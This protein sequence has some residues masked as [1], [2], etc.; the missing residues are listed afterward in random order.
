LEVYPMSMSDKTLTAF[1]AETASNAPT[2]G[3]GSV[4][5]LTGALGCALAEMVASL[6]V[7]KAKFADSAP[8][9]EEILQ[10]GAALR[11]KLLAL[12]DEDCASFGQYMSALALPKDTPA[13]KDARRES[14]RAAA[15]A[16]AAAPMEMARAAAAALPLCERAVRLG[17]P[18]V[19][20]DALMATMLARTAVRSA[21]LNVRINLPSIGD[22]AAAAALDAECA[23][24]ESL[25]QKTEEELMALSPV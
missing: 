14:L 18:G 15:R 13:Q 3:G 21:V 6:T 10:E 7:G 20:T 5:A 22:E 19:V 25:A 12:I 11:A 23:R 17:N 24:L 8:A 16:A 4:A 9:M 2:P 1:C